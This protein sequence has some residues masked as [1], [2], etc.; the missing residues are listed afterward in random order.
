[1]S[2]RT[3]P[4][5]LLLVIFA[6]F[7]LSACGSSGGSSALPPATPT[8]TLSGSVFAAPVSGASV[9][10]LN[11]AGTETIAGPVAT[12]VD[13]SYSLKFP[14]RSLAEDLLIVSSAGTFVDEATGATT[15]AGHMAAV[16]PAGT[17]AS[18]DQ[19][20]LD[21]ASTIIAN[22]MGRHS[23]TR[24]E[25]LSTFVSVFSYTPDGAIGPRNEPYSS[26]TSTEQRLAA[27]RAMTFSQLTKDLGLSPA[28]QFD[29]FEAIADDLADGTMDGMDNGS[30]VTL[31][32]GWLPL[33][34]QN[35]FERSLVTMLSDTTRNLTGL[36]PAQIGVLPFAKVALTQS[37]RID[38]IPGMMPAK[39]GK[40]QF[41]IRVTKRSDGLAAPGLM[42]SLMPKMHMATMT[43]STPVDAVTD[44]GDGTYSCTV[45]YLMASGPD[46][47]FWELKV[48]AGTEAATFFPA[49][50]MA[51]GSTSVR[52]TLRGQADDLINTM[53]GST[54]RSYYLFKDGMATVSKVDLYLA[55][56]GNMMMTYPALFTGATLTNE[57]N[58]P[59]TIVNM[60]VEATTNPLNDLSWVAGTNSTGGHWSVSGLSLSSGQ[61]NTIYL[62]LVVN[63]VQKS[64][65]GNA[66]ANPSDANG[67]A[68]FLVQPGL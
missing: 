52:A 55:A 49:V 5:L 18:G 16:I 39:V 29:L 4:L 63:G 6:V 56:Q 33:D 15:P 7:S 37:Y 47:G 62:R 10:I 54:P 30:S 23:K 21:P 1:M 24:T 38:Y 43:H 64:T 36:G 45:Y 59:W 53:T 34:I 60:S 9:A 48:M 42:V 2:H 68:M 20:T 27:L 8:A 19:V 31:G 11:S 32:T 65:D 12:A 14:A 17:V 58:N 40:T 13:G 66:V 25:A 50:G 28:R 3:F 26:T 22:L 35:R 57:T 67:Y 46:M 51:M 61:T 41:T 44:N